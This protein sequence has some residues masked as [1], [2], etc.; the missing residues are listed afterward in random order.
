MQ[1]AA[2][3]ITGGWLEQARQEAD[4]IEWAHIRGSQAFIVLSLCRLLYSLETGKVASKSAAA[5]WALKKLGEC[6]Q[7]L[8]GQAL[9][10]QHDSRLTTEEQYEAM[11]DLLKYCAG[12]CKTTAP[13]N[14]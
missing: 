3:V 12:Q 14:G 8:I 1:Q 10:S 5:G 4:W 9:A 13:A 2:A 7:A 6:W 11:L